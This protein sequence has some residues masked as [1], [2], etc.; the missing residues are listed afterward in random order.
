MHFGYAQCKQKGFAPILI[1]ILIAAALGG[2]LLYSQ[3]TKPT[4]LSPKPVI[5]SQ[6]PIPPSSFNTQ[7]VGT[8]TPQD[9]AG[10]SSLNQLPL[11]T[12]GIQWTELYADTWPY[13]ATDKDGTFLGW[14]RVSGNARSNRAIG[15]EDLYQYVLDIRNRL[16]STGWQENISLEALGP[17]GWTYA[18]EKVGDDGKKRIFVLT[19]RGEACIDR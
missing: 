9:E 5:T 4:T 12:P 6:I 1:V 19:N 11:L 8:P 15:D 16:E 13:Y 3:L 14:K 10:C 2:Y 7:L 18:E 17:G